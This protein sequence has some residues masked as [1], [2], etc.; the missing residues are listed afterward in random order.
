VELFSK[1]RM[2]GPDPA[3][4]VTGPILKKMNLPEKKIPPHHLVRLTEGKNMG[5]YSLKERKNGP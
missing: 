3:Y 5:Y 1:N 4:P 2:G